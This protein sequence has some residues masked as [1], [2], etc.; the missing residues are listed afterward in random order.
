MRCLHVARLRLR[1][2]FRAAA[3]ERELDDEVRFHVEQ[4]TQLEVAR[5][6]RPDEARIIALRAIGGLAQIKERSRGM[7][8]VASHSST[9]CSRTSAMASARSARIAA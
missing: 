7:R 4:R 5:G 8:R 6:A 1:S 2:L 3:V 9:S